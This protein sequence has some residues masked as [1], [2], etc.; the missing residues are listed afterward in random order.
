MASAHIKNEIKFSSCTEIQNGAVA[1]SH[2]RKG[3]LILHMRKCAN[4]EPYMR[5][6]V[7]IYEFA[8]APL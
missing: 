6:P 4:I 1:K 8:T 3:F 2:M 5:R 7:V